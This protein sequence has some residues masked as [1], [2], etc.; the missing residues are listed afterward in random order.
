MPDHKTD[1]QGKQFPQKH[2]RAHVKARGTVN[3]TMPL[4]R[5]KFERLIA[6]RKETP[7]RD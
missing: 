1:S 7:R 5:R 2:R 6:P 4:E 3:K